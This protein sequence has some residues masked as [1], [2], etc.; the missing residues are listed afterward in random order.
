LI[1]PPQ[2]SVAAVGGGLAVVE[3]T[4][5]VVSEIT[6]RSRLRTSGSRAPR[7]SIR[8][9]GSTSRGGPKIDKVVDL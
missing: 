9:A 5:V 4:T 7:G 2:G 1:I 3:E 8:Q 6:P